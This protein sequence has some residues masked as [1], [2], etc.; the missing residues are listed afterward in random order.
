MCIHRLDKNVG[1][2]WL[3]NDLQFIPVKFMEVLQHSG[4][5]NIDED[6]TL[7]VNQTANRFKN[8]VVR[9]LRYMFQHIRENDKIEFLR[10][11]ECGHVGYDEVDV[12]ILL[13]P[14]MLGC[15]DCLSADV[16]SENFA[17]GDAACNEL[18]QCTKSTS[19]FQDFGVS[20]QSFLLQ[21]S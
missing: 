14:A 5:R 10:V 17:I 13:L 11:A 3:V 18:S 8:I 7:F 2:Q 9:L 16:S 15:S 20:L 1:M 6:H 4:F 19:D 12:S 21:I